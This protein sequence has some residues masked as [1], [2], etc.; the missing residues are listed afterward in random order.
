MRLSNII[1]KPLITEKSFELVSGNKYVFEV[2]LGAKKETIKK[3]IKRIY[4]VDPLEVNTIILP[5]KKRRILKTRRF[6]K[7]GK[8]KKAIV[9]LKEGQSIDVFPKD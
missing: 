7:S 4:G 3:E 9:K 2:S 1:T 6:T 8:T 5:G